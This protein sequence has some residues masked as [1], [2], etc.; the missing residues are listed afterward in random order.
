MTNKLYGANGGWATIRSVNYDGIGT[1]YGSDYHQ[2]IPII[3]S[4]EWNKMIVWCVKT[5]GPSG[6]KDLPG[7]WSINERWYANNAKFYFKDKKD[8]EWFM[9]RW[10]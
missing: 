8:C 9:L 5:Y 2:I 7:A 6:T 10:S 3:T 1:V 4:E